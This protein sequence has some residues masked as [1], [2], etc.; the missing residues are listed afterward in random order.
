MKIGA[1]NFLNA[2][3]LCHQLS[4][5]DERWEIIEAP[6]SELARALRGGDID[7]G[8]VPQVEACNDPRYRIVPGYCISCDGEVGSIL[9]F[10]KKDWRELQVV[11]V[12]RASNSSVALLQVLRHL[13]DLPPLK[14]EEI[15]S[16]LSRLEDSSP[17]DGILL[18]GDAALQH[19]SANLERIDLG[20]AWKQR[21][22]LPFVF[23]VWLSRDRLPSSVVSGLQNAAK[24]GLELREQIAADFTS[25]NPE[26]LD[27]VSARDYLYQNICYH[28]G[29]DQIEALHS[30]HKLRSEVDGSID[31]EWLPQLLGER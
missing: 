11:G 3:P 15:N 29:E 27:F 8:L 2:L 16:D 1:I 20:L 18:I 26:I 19:R 7:V 17:L 31:Q 10:L 13:D 6:P 14:F 5:Q 21:T 22:G 24:R 28:L 23:A 4:H 9:L 25:A 12:D 30:F